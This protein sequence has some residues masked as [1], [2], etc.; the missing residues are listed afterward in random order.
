[1]FSQLDMKSNYSYESNNFTIDNGTGE[2]FPASL[3]AQIGAHNLT[4]LA[5]NQSDDTVSDEATVSSC[6]NV[7]SPRA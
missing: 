5:Y 3:L 6:L 2:I 4:V 7:I 1:M